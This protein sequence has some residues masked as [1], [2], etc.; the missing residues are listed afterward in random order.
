[1]TNIEDTIEKNPVAGVSFIKH[2][3]MNVMMPVHIDEI[4]VSAKSCTP[5]DQH[6]VVELWQILDGS[7]VL[8]YQNKEYELKAGDRFFFHTNEAHQIRNSEE[9]ELKILSIYWKAE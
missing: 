9:Y 1:M 2:L 6:E 3:K 7:G 8:T 5:V 4:V